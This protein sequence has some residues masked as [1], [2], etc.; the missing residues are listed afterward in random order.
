LGTGIGLT[1]LENAVLQHVLITESANKKHLQDKLRV[2]VDA[3]KEETFGDTQPL[4]YLNHHKL[5]KHE[6]C[7]HAT[8]LQWHNQ[9][10]V[11]KIATALNPMQLQQ[12]L[13]YN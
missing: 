5:L 2:L 9:R 3:V 1:E 11:P 7:D 12:Q 6:H 10:K 4:V 13:L 8:I